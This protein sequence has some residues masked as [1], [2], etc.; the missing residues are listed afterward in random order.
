MQVRDRIAIVSRKLCPALLV[1]NNGNN[2]E[3]TFAECLLCLRHN[4][5]LFTIC[6]WGN[7][8]TEVDTLSEETQLVNITPRSVNG[9][10]RAYPTSGPGPVINEAFAL[11][12]LMAGRAAD[13]WANSA[14]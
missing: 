11:S 10:L 7:R 13:G 6:R 9:S 3:Q 2:N 14:S 4:S 5:K 1:Q 12:E 8:P